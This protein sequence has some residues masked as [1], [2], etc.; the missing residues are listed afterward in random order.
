[1][2]PLLGIKG[3]I[4]RLQK[5]TLIILLAVISITFVSSIKAQQSKDDQNP[6]PMFENGFWWIT[7]SH[8]LIYAAKLRT[9]PFPMA[10]RLFYHKW[11]VVGEEKI[12]G[13][14]CWV[15]NIYAYDVPK[16]VKNDQGSEYL[17]RIHLRKSNLTLARFE[18]NIRSGMYLVTGDKGEKIIEDYS[19][20]NP[21]IVTLVPEILPLE[22]PIIPNT[23]FA[24]GLLEQ[25]K[26]KIFYD[27]KTNFKLI[28]RYEPFYSN[29]TSVDELS[30]PVLIISLAKE[31]GTTIFQKWVPGFPWWSEWQCFYRNGM[32]KDLW[33]SKTIDWKDK[34]VSP[35]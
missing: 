21:S 20:K 35:E 3:A 32:I 27:E 10:D 11:Q 18:T 30:K 14:E 5:Y 25:E 16:T 12:H 34:T 4:M 29:Y 19:K 17:F 26:E 2:I 6:V 9:G 22:F 8:T 7:E 33:Y 13:D 15:V 1:L 31:D 23:W 28:Q 24:R